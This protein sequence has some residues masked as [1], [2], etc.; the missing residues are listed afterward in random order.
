M[1]WE[2]V[3]ALIVTILV[4]AFWQNQRFEDL[5]KRIDDLRDTMDV[6][7]KAVD[8][9]IDDLRVE[10]RAAFADLRAD[11]RALAEA[12]RART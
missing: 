1:T 3:G 7:F 12:L 2:Q 5:H 8:K 10:I 4:A 9:Q 11:V 6:R